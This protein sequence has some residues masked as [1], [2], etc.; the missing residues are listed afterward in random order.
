MDDQDTSRRSKMRSTRL[1]GKNTSTLVLHGVYPHPYGTNYHY[2]LKNND[3]TVVAFINVAEHEDVDDK[4]I[5][6]VYEVEVRQGF[7]RQG[8][9]RTIITSVEKLTGKKIVTSGAYTPEGL[10][11]LAPHYYGKEEIQSVHACYTSMTF[12]EDWD[13]MTPKYRA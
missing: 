12:V 11:Y 1:S 7:R 9:A 5:L 8:F 6:H 10:K 13:S 2:W 3:G 4:N